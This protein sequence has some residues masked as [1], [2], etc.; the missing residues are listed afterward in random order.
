MDIPVEAIDDM[1]TAAMK[2]TRLLNNNPR[3][4]TLDDA[5]Q[6]YKNAY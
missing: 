4:I 3:E 2:V 1:A 5:R 6:I